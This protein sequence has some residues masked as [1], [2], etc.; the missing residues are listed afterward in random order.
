MCMCLSVCVYVCGLSISIH[1]LLLLLL[2]PPMRL[3]NISAVSSSNEK[4]E[5]S[6]CLLSVLVT[7]TISGCQISPSQRYSLTRLPNIRELAEN[8]AD[9]QPDHCHLAA[10]L[11]LLPVTLLHWKGF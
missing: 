9:W 7:T 3:G 5:Q 4:D 6:S 10:V 8:E 2:L 1:V 11:C